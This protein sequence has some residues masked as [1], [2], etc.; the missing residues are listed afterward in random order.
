MSVPA[1]LNLEKLL[2]TPRDGAL[3]RFSL[4][5][6]Y[7]KLLQFDKAS[8]YFQQ[9]LEKDPN[10]SAAWK[11]LGQALQSSGK[12]QQALETW[13]RGAVVAEQRGDKQAAKVMAVFAKRLQKQIGTTDA[14][15]EGLPPA[16]P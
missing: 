4:G 1:I 16:P 6:E 8:V 12:L 5:N 11:E 13:Q 7:L 9:A 15:I 10:Y 3:L 2:D 14:D